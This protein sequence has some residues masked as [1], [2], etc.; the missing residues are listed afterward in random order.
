MFH[1]RYPSRPPAL[2]VARTAMVSFLFVFI[3]F[4]CGIAMGQSA[5][6]GETQ[7]KSAVDGL[8]AMHGDA[9]RARI[10]KGVRQAA[11]MWRAE[12]GTPQDFENFCK[13][14]FIADPQVLQQTTNHFEQY[15]EGLYGHF[16]EMG[17]DL[18]WYLDVESGPILPIDYAFAQYSPGAH[19]SDDLFKIKIAFI[20]L[21]NYPQYTLEERLRLGPSW[22]REQW[23]RP[24]WRRCSPIAS[25]RT[26]RNGSTKRT[27]RPPTMS[28]NT[29]SGCTTR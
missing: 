6:I 13:E 2:R 24:G 27:C 11:Q 19:V 17:R 9:Q 15:F 16:N 10:D 21:L 12:D 26:S 20:A 3:F 18:S 22:T 5:F 1:L 23:H 14:N 7:I 8:A 4:G 29:T 28:A 25:P